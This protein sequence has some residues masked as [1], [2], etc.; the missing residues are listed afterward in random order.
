M[1]RAMAHARRGLGRTSPNPVVGACVVAADDV[2]VGDGSHERAGEAH[3]EVVALQHAGE[4]A[5]GGTLYCTLEP[6]VHTGRTGPCTDRIIEAGIARVV[7]AMEDPYPLVHGRGFAKLREHG[8]TVEVGVG[9]REAARLNQPFVTTM[10]QGRPF[11]I[12][13]AATSLDGR[14]AAGLGQR[15]QIT[16]LQ[17][18]RHSHEL[19]AQVD[20]LAVGSETVVVD[21]P[22]LTPRLV[23]RERPLTRVVFDRRLR[24]DPGARL[25]ST[26][27]SGPVIIVTTVEAVRRKVAR[28]EALE[29]AG[30]TLL[31]LESCGMPDAVRALGRLGVQS[32]VLEGGTMLHQAAWDAGIVDYVQLYVGPAAF[33]GDAPRLLQDRRFSTAA[34]YEPRVQLL[35]PDVLIEGYVHRPD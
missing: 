29:A 17:A 12:L 25:F 7:A 11:V 9:G 2:V 26:L 18:E 13:K 15:T 14:L 10:R 24:T 8:I 28:V 5:R 6:C 33:G 23:Y 34:S 30:A 16:S 22:L 27:S 3:A 31:A 35:G 1:R 19:R 21:D 20:A 32:L 4:R